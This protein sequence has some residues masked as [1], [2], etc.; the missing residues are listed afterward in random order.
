V[1]TGGLQVGAPTGGAKGTGTINVAADIYKNNSA[2]TNPDYVLEH[3]ATGE[4]VKHAHKHGAKDYRGLMPLAGVKNF[5]RRNF[6]LPGFGPKA[7][8]GLF[9]GG[10]GLLASLEQA[11]LY[12]FQLEERL[13]K[14]EA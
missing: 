9:S 14:L 5:A 11:Y 4:I 13:S 1:I 10:D 3:W 2:Y 12:I 6:H 7:K 8:H